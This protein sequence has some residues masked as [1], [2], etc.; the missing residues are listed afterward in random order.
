MLRIVVLA[1]VENCKHVMYKTLHRICFLGWL[2]KVDRSDS[3]CH[4]N[5]AVFVAL[6]PSSP[7]SELA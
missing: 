4:K 5:I 3:F 6:A 2:T 1:S 7:G